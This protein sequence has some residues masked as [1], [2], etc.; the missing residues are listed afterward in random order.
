MV[1][2]HVKFTIGV[3]VLTERVKGKHPSSSKGIRTKNPD[4]EY[5]AMIK[6]HF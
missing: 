2:K 1:H 5:H 4:R 6:S 3:T